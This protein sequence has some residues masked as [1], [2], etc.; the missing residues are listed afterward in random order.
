MS[1]NKIRYSPYCIIKK[2]YAELST[3][4]A[5]SNL[6]YLDLLGEHTLF[7]ILDCK[8]LVSIT[9]QDCMVNTIS[10]CK[11]LNNIKIKDCHNLEYIEDCPKL[12][13]IIINRSS[14]AKINASNLKV[15]K[16]TD[17]EHVVDIISP[18]LSKL[19]IK[20]CNIFNYSILNNFPALTYLNL[21]NMECEYNFANLYLLKVLKLDNC[22]NLS[23]IKDLSYLDKIIIKNCI[24]LRSVIS[25]DQVKNIKID[26]CDLL[27]MIAYVEC[28]SI[29]ISRCNYLNTLENVYTKLLDLS[30]CDRFHHCN[31]VA[32]EFIFKNTSIIEICVFK[33]T[34]KISV[35][36]CSSFN[37][38]RYLNSCESYAYENLIITLDNSYCM[39][40]LK[41]LKAGILEILNC[42]N[43]ETISEL[44]NLK[45]LKVWNCENLLR[46]TD[47][48]ITN[49]IDIRICNS[50]VDI[51]NIM[52]V[53]QVHLYD[54]PNLSKFITS[55]S[56]FQIVFI[57]MCPKLSC[58]LN[59]PFLYDLTLIDCGIV[60]IDNIN[61][62]CVINI[63]DVSWYKNCLT[64]LSDPFN[65]Y[66]HI[67]DEAIDLRGYYYKCKTVIS[68][69][70]NHMRDYKNKNK[71][72]FQSKLNQKIITD[73]C[74]IC[75]NVISPDTGVITGCEHVFHRLCIN[76]W[77]AYSRNQCC[78]ICKRNN[79]Q[80]R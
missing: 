2:G 72:Y 24:D 22:S 6:I 13:S 48:V 69:I 68:I 23:T 43:I 26:S 20:N 17:T 10:G 64:V 61:I 66:T 16:L 57:E 78:P 4:K 62:N 45:K 58:S 30:Y 47:T 31:V 79:I 46:I 28:D 41:S 19:K 74:S 50:I 15:L 63:Q 37:I 56:Y 44:D 9:L 14:I 5:K 54:L 73:T 53:S 52:G 29:K 36:N 3:E 21:I 34:N 1:G 8:L 51:D 7:S 39:P 67:T 77:F 71:I 70:I 75:I 33:E 35:T 59:G 55:F 80:L 60:L 27:T 38:F 18:K 11:L 40:H 42:D 49:D 65:M 25:L 76:S 12:T 32:I